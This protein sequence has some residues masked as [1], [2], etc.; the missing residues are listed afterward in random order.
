MQEQRLDKWLWCARLFKTRSLASEAV[1]SGRIT[2]N[3]S[4]TKPARII[5]IG[6]AV[7]I[8]RP[9]YE[10]RLSVTGITQ[11]R[12]PASR[13]STLYLESEDSVIRREELSQSIKASA[14]VEDR[15]AGK[16]TKKQRRE[17]ERVK[18]SM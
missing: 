2:V 16:I 4:R 18:R 13:V 3:G 14:I 12:V 7:Y 5:H 15:R 8:R 10:F 6:D 11:Q 9:P 17:R 1:K